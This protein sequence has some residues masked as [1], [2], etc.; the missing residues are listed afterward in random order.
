MWQNY[1]KIEPYKT[2]C[3]EVNLIKLDEVM[4]AFLVSV[5]TSGHPVPERDKLLA[6]GH[7]SPWDFSL[8]VTAQCIVL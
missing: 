3:E 8:R 5:L 4:L 6:S 7:L 2:G 1:S